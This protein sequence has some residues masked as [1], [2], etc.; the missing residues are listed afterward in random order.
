MASLVMR[1]EDS[2]RPTMCGQ[3]LHVNNGKTVR[4]EEPLDHTKRELR[5]VLVVNRVELIALEHPQQVRK[6]HRQR[7]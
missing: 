7:T 3:L 2:K 1:R 5:E 6:L 4:A